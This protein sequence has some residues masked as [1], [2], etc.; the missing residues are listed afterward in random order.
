MLE[1]KANI[2]RLGLIIV[3][4]V[5]WFVGP[6]ILPLSWSLGLTGLAVIIGLAL[7]F[8]REHD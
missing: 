3:A 6:G 5:A 8:F 4:G 1:E 2:N 7:S